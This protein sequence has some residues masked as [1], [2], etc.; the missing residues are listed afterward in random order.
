M[1]AVAAVS[2]AGNERSPFLALGLLLSG[3]YAA[4]FRSA[5]GILLLGLLGLVVAAVLAWRAFG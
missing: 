3:A 4:Y 5:V 1:L 2:H